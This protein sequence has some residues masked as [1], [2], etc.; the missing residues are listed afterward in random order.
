MSELYY[1]TPSLSVLLFSFLL[2]TTYFSF[3]RSKTFCQAEPQPRNT[4]RV[5]WVRLFL[6]PLHLSFSKM[7]INI[8]SWYIRLGG[9][10]EYMGLR[11]TYT[12]ILSSSHAQHLLILRLCISLGS[13]ALLRCLNCKGR[14]FRRAANQSGPLR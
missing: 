7:D 8:L 11:D 9:A 10:H 12:E 5:V 14:S 13:T 3:L 4:Y 6:L 2:Y 1:R